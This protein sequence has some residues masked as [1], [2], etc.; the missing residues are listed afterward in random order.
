[1]IFAY[2]AILLLRATVCYCTAR[3]DFPF[4]THSNK[5]VR[6]SSCN[7]IVLYG[8]RVISPKRYV[9]A[10]KLI[11]QSNP[12]VIPHILPWFVS[13]DVLILKRKC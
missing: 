4:F 9:L 2:G 12:R 7:T 11:P 5:T 8:K 13:N 3:G 1:M 10:Q 6:R